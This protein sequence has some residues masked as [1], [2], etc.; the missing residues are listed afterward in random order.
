MDLLDLI[1]ILIRLYEEK[2][3]LES[4]HLPNDL[5]MLMAEKALLLPVKSNHLIDKKSHRWDVHV[6][7]PN[8][9][10]CIANVL[11]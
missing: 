3:L 2:Q 11:Q 10:N 6:K 4:H 7:K 5:M 8:V 1:V 9:S